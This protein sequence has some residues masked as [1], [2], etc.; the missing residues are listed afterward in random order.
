M[1]LDLKVPM[2]KQAES[3]LK[4]ENG[5]VKGDATPSPSPKKPASEFEK[6]LKNMPGDT[7]LVKDWTD[8]TF[9]N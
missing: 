9:K 5:A 8:C 7:S 1:S 6:K 3:K 4:I 2:L